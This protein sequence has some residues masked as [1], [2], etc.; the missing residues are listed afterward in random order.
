MVQ[1]RSIRSVVYLC[2]FVSS[3]STEWARVTFHRT[4]EM[5]SSACLFILLY[6]SNKT[7]QTKPNQIRMNSKKKR[8]SH[9]NEL[10]HNAFYKRTVCALWFCSTVISCYNS[11]N[12]TFSHVFHSVRIVYE[13][14]C[15]GRDLNIWFEAQQT[16]NDTEINSIDELATIINDY[17]INHIKKE[18]LKVKLRKKLFY[19]RKKRI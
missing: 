15:K 12:S 9:S 16:P 17:I 1:V 8:C 3:L 4:H 5:W 6:W 7:N 19:N 18:V 10:P 11:I 13:F 14:C 2:C